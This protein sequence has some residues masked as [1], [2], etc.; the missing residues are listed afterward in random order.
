MSLKEER[1]KRKR[2]KNVTVLVVHYCSLSSQGVGRESMGE[3]DYVS[4]HFALSFV[5]YWKSSRRHVS[6]VRLRVVVKVVCLVLWL[7]VTR[8]SLRL[9]SC[10]A[11]GMATLFHL[12]L[13]GKRSKNL[14]RKLLITGCALL[15]LSCCIWKNICVIFCPFVLSIVVLASQFISAG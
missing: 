2:K 4:L 13:K 8:L 1:G 10:H 9:W 14:D 5:D 11:S 7:W 3:L 6:V 15:H 12:S